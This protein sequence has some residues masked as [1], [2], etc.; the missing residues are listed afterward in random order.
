MQTKSKSWMYFLCLYASLCFPMGTIYFYGKHDLIVQGTWH[1]YRERSRLPSS[2]VHLGGHCYSPSE[3]SVLQ[4]AALIRHSG[5]V[6]KHPRI[7]WSP[8]PYAGWLA[9]FGEKMVHTR[10]GQKYL[11]SSSLW[12]RRGSKGHPSS[13]V[14]FC[15]GTAKLRKNRDHPEGLL[16]LSFSTWVENSGVCRPP[17]WPFKQES[18]GSKRKGKSMKYIPKAEGTV[19]REGKCDLG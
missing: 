10:V 1:P 12:S 17:W 9:G 13:I 2:V 8:S 5:L 6:L 16:G 3:E 19:R 18:K 14:L 15:K 7:T 4:V 11:V